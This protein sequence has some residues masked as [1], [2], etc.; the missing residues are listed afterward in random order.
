MKFSQNPRALLPPLFPHPTISV[1]YLF[2][3]LFT[4]IEDTGQTLP[5]YSDDL[6]HEPIHPTHFQ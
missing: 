1:S 2:G 5:L 3:G 4:E 6:I